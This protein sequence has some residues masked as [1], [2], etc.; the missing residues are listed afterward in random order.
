MAGGYT[1]YR[2]D[3]DKNFMTKFDASKWTEFIFLLIK[4]S[5]SAAKS[6]RDGLSVL[7]HCSDG[8][9]RTSQLSALSQLFIDPYYRTLEGFAILIEKDF[10]SLRD[11]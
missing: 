9:D 5:I 7:I 1:M 11:F 4:R 10:V 6:V 8:W 3:E 2:P